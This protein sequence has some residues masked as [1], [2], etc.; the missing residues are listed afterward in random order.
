MGRSSSSYGLVTRPGCVTRPRQLG[1]YPQRQD[2]LPMCWRATSS[3]AS[4]LA[5]LDLVVAQYPLRI[6]P[7][8]KAPRAKALSVPYCPPPSLPIPDEHPS[9]MHIDRRR[10]DS[11]FM[12]WYA[13]AF[14][15]PAIVRR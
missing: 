3:G 7:S 6:P 8:P 4:T 2:K 13:T 9:D 1:G 14:K 5:R 11:A 15:P 10:D 12:Y